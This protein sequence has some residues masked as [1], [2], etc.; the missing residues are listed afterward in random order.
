MRK[1]INRKNLVFWVAGIVLVFALVLL[2]GRRSG[3][4]SRHT[5]EFA[6]GDTSSIKWIFMA[7][8]NGGQVLLQRQSPGVWLLNGKERA[9]QENIDDLLSV[10][11]NIKV[12]MPVGK[13]AS[14]NV[15]KWLATGATKVQV[16]YSGYRIR[17]G[18]FCFWRCE[19]NRVFHIGSP[20]PDNLG[21]YAIMDGAKQPYIVHVPGFRG[22]ISPY[23]TT[24]VTDW[25]SHELLNLR[26]SE[27]AEVRLTDVGDPSGSY[28]VRRNGERHFDLIPLS[29]FRPLP[30]YDTIKLYEHLS[31]YRKLN[32]EF[33]AD[34]MSVAKRDSILSV[35]FRELVVTDI[36]GKSLKNNMYLMW[37]DLRTDEYEYNPDFMDIYNRDKFYITLDDDTTKFYICQYF[38]FDRI[39]QPVSYYYIDNK[40]KAIQ[41]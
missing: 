31:S 26:M 19:K 1:I 7:D 36:H 35:K 11:R 9:L 15:I 21:N 30:V 40:E 17:I 12:K 16:C 14:E 2:A 4:Y 28:L 34:S 6:V 37:N 41:R 10:I 3:T 5:S 27:I 18:K 24:L 8:R 38:V 39:I 13:A 23:F 32:F 20:T 25:Q 22:F 33:F 29:D